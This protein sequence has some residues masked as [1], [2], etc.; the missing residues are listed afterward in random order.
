MRGAD[1]ELLKSTGAHALGFSGPTPGRSVSPKDQPLAAPSSMWT[2]A[3]LAVKL[4]MHSFWSQLLQSTLIAIQKWR[5]DACW[6][7][8]WEQG[9]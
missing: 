7:S 2:G 9:I 6:G 8:H 3:S 1:D 4:K 5:N